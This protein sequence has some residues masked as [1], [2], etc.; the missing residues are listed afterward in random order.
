MNNEND[1]FAPVKTL[2][3]MH[4]LTLAYDIDICARLAIYNRSLLGYLR[5]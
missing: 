3:L 2:C 5:Q 1:F 4:K